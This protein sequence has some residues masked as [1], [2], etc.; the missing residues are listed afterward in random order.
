MRKPRKR[1]RSARPI[2][3]VE[4]DK[5]TVT[6]PGLQAVYYKPANRPQLVLK[7]RNETDNHELLARAWQAANEKARELGWIV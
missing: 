7:R 3:G 4:G 6:L 2:V 1:R 5:I